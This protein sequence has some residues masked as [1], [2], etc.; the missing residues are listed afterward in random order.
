LILRPITKLRHV[1]RGGYRDLIWNATARFGALVSLAVATLV[2]ARAGGPTAVGIYALMRVLPSLVGVMSS[3]GLPGSVTYFFAGDHRGDRRLPT[4]VLTIALAG[5]VGGALLWLAVSPV[6][7]RALLSDLSTGLVAVS[8]VLVLTRVLVA[9]AKSCSQGRDDLP[10]ANRVIVTEEFMFLPVYGIVVLSGVGGLTAVMAGM[11]LADLATLS[12]AWGRL[13]RRGFFDA[14]RRPSKAL[15]REIA[16]YGIRAQTGGVISLLNLRLDFIVLSVLTGPAVLGVYAVASKFAELVRIPGMSVTYV[17]YP[18]FAKAG[19]AKAAGWARKLLTRACII[20]GATVVPLFL[21]AG[22]LIPTM[23]GSQFAS[24]TL[25]AQII[26]VGLVTQG[27]TAVGTAF[28]YGVGRPGLNSVA[29]GVGLVVTVVLD[30]LLIPPFH[31]T[32]A[33]VASAVAY[34]VNSLVLLWFLLRLGRPVRGVT[35]TVP[36]TSSEAGTA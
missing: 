17:L 9:T 28:L 35:A 6:L 33:A 24:A 27:I 23:Y 13:I 25:P 1:I 16:S 20:T 4:T 14:A 34:T 3:A 21:T 22:F 15:A 8:A 31:A 18:R 32:G 5:G 10:G 19:P 29:V 2:V 11:I 7:Q 26:L 36:R 12:L 30:F